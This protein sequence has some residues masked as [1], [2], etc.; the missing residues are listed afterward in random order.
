[1]MMIIMHGDDDDDDDDGDDDDDDDGLPSG[2]SGV[3]PSNGPCLTSWRTS[4]S[5]TPTFTA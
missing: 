1:M 3:L 5:S 2:K 4:L